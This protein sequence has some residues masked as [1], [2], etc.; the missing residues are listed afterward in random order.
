MTPMTP[1]LVLAAVEAIPET[2]ENYR[3]VRAAR[4]DAQTLVEQEN[5]Q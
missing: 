5:T 1:A 4:R 2:P 3:Q